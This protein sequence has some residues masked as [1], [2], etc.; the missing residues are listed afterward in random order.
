MREG[1]SR[2]AEKEQKAPWCYLSVSHLAGECGPRRGEG[3]SLNRA[4]LLKGTGAMQEAFLE[5]KL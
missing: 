5:V 4:S 3:P 1:L 2:V